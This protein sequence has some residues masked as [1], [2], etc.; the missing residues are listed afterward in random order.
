VNQQSCPLLLLLLQIITWEF[1]DR[2]WDA[3]WGWLLLSSPVLLVLQNVEHALCH[4]EAAKVRSRGSSVPCLLRCAVG[5]LR[6]RALP[7]H[8]LRIS[9][10]G[11][12]VAQRHATCGCGAAC[13]TS[14]LCGA[15]RRLGGCFC[16]AGVSGPGSTTP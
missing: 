15:G 7:W 11:A 1:E 5:G 2:P 8:A 6:C 9:P 3:L 4:S 13:T 16:R 14:C 10:C 12:C